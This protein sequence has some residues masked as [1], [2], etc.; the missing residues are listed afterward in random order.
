MGKYHKPKGRKQDSE[1][2]IFYDSTNVNLKMRQNYGL[3][4]RT[5]VTLGRRG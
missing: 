3:E 2:C 4:V 5:V 1:E